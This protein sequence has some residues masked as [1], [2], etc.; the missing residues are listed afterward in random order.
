MYLGHHFKPSY[1][2][3]QR[4]K[5][6][7]F[8]QITGNGKVILKVSNPELA[9]WSITYPGPNPQNNKQKLQMVGIPNVIELKQNKIISV[10]EHWEQ[11]S[12]PEWPKTKNTV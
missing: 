10:E 5:I 12:S 6:V 8:I 9:E 1:L 3:L 4:T 7:W 2:F 11:G